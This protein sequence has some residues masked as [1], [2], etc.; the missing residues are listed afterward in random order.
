MT[1][2]IHLT[3]FNPAQAAAELARVG[4]WVKAMT[5]A[6][7]RLVLSIRTETRSTKQNAMMWSCL[8]D[9]STQVT[10]FGKKLTKEGWKDFITGHLDGQELVPNMDG[11]GF[12]SIQR[13]RSTSNM[14]IRE[15]VAVIDLCHAFGAEQGVNWSPT[16]LG[17][18]AFVVDPETGEI[19]ETTHAPRQTEAA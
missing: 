18:D 10:W 14:T 13:G 5:M 6:D 15:M 12:I 16:S 3:L 19:V 8:T 9:L 2:R 4:A 1:D 17:R 11:T 7:N